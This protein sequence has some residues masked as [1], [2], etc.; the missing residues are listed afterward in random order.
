MQNRIF[1]LDEYRKEIAESHP[2]M[3]RKFE[4][5]TTDKREEYLKQIAMAESVAYAILW[6]MDHLPEF[7]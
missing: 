7:P 5:L 1:D 3:A 4:Q 2:E 6:A